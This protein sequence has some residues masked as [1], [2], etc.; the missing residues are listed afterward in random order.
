LLRRKNDQVNKKELARVATFLKFAKDSW[1]PLE[2][3][4]K[5]WRL[6]EAVGASYSRL[7]TFGKMLVFWRLVEIAR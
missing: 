1:S 3:A 7:K 2:F 6:Q 5:C 4:A